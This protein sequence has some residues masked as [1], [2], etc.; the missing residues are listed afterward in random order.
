MVS[1]EQERRNEILST[2]VHQTGTLTSSTVAT[3]LTLVWVQPIWCATMTDSEKLHY[4]LQ[5]LTLIRD[6]YGQV[7]QQFEICRHTSCN[8]SYTSWAVADATLRKIGGTLEDN[9]WA[10]IVELINDMKGGKA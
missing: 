10:E 2:V 8:S 5:A 1:F 9:D 7:C 3:F 4:A 6:A